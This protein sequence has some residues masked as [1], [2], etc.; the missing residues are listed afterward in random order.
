[1][2]TGPT[3]MQKD[4]FEKYFKFDLLS[5]VGDKVVNVRIALAKA[6]R[7]HF[8]KEIAGEFVY[9]KMTGYGVYDSSSKHYEGQ[10]LYGKFKGEG[11]LF[12][13]SN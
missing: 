1:M 11:K 12:V 5:L 7:H 6:L 4:N 2:V 9:D 8:L 3:M 10:F 13:N